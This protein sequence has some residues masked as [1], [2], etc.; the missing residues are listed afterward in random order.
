VKK[1]LDDPIKLNMLLSIA[2]VIDARYK[3][4]YISFWFENIYDGDK[5]SDLIKRVELT[6]N[7][8]YE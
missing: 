2:V 7:R 3:L 4:K 1:Y 8:L 6:L 5:R